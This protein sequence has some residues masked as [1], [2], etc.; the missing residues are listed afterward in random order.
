VV[1][2][3][4]LAKTVEDLGV[5]TLVL[6]GATGARWAACSPCSAGKRTPLKA[7]LV[8]AGIDVPGRMRW[9]VSPIYSGDIEQAGT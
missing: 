5:A 6:E 1:R 4:W 9:N 8:A 2:K 3:Q 7:V